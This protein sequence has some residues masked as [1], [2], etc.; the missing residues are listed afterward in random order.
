MEVGSRG[1]V[2]FYSFRR[3]AEK[4]HQCIK[5]RTIRLTTLT[6]TSEAIKGSFKINFGSAEIPLTAPKLSSNVYTQYYL[7]C[8]FY[9]SSLYMYFIMV[10]LNCH[11][12]AFVLGG[13]L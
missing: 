10:I 5:E 4:C 3:L 7:L 2:N 6:V 11:H 1:F 9:H 13:L 12:D 8:T